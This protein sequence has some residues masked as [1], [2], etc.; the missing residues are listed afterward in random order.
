MMTSLTIY[1]D[2]M[3]I[4]C[5]NLEYMHDIKGKVCNNF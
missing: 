3:I 1:I 4:A 5:A 2:D